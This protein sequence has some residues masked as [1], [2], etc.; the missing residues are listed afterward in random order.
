MTPS[1]QHAARYVFPDPSHGLLA[2]FVLTV[3]AASAFS[4]GLSFPDDLLGLQQ[5]LIK[6][7]P[8]DQT[9]WALATVLTLSVAGGVLGLPVMLMI[10]LCAMLFGAVPGML[11]SLTGCLAGAILAYAA[12]YRIDPDS[13]VFATRPA[14]LVHHRLRR[15]GLTAILLLRLSPLMPF[16]LVNLVAGAIRVRWRDYVLG[17]LLGMFP[18]I[19]L[20]SLVMGRLHTDSGRLTAPHASTALIALLVILLAA[21]VGPKLSRRHAIMTG[22]VATPL[23]LPLQL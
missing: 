10:A 12:A 9:S 20:I 1:S 11:Y 18:S 15:G 21:V 22:R 3:L 13:L 14:R 6:V 7:L 4:S 23:E 16:T 8:L 2:G 17:T 5:W 19:V